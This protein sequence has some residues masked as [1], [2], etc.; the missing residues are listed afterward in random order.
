MGLSELKRN[1]E[2]QQS[3]LRI[4]D[5]TLHEDI[6]Q[7]L[8][9]QERAATALQQYS[10]NRSKQLQRSNDDASWYCPSWLQGRHR[11]QHRH[12][13]RATSTTQPRL[14]VC[15]FCHIHAIV[16]IVARGSVRVYMVIPNDH[17]ST[18]RSKIRGMLAS[19]LAYE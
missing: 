13:H 5:Q 15:T 4:T 17:W 1:Q 16:H 10:S 19:V 9:K 6:R 2:R 3:F 8:Q 18:H 14:N 11:H 7:I 12:C